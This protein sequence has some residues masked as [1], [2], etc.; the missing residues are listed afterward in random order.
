MKTKPTDLTKIPVYFKKEHL[1]YI[2]NSNI[3]L[4]SFNMEAIQVIMDILEN[5]YPKEIKDE[6]RER[7]N[8][9]KK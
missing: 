2:N 8:R 7:V 6:I 3:S 4:T 5:D 9:L 1:Q